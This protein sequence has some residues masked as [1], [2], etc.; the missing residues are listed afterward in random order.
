MNRATPLILAIALFMQ[1]MDSTVIATALPAI[2]IDIGTDPIAL[3]LA[4][5]SYL[6]ALAMFIP[7]SGWMGERFGVKRVFAASILVFVAGSILCAFADSLGTFVVYRF[8]QGMGGAMMMP[9]ARVILAR[10]TPRNELIRAMSWLTIPALIGPLAGP[11]VG[12]F[13]TTYFSWHWI[14]FINVPIGLVGV[15]AVAIF[16][17]GLPSTLVR[18]MDWPGFFLASISF[19]GLLFGLSVVSQPILPAGYGITATLLGL[20]AGLGYIWHA[21][22]AEHPLLQLSLFQYPLF[23][24]GIAGGFI[25]RIAMGATPFLLPLMLQLGFGLSPFQSGLI[26]FYSAVG[27]IAAKFTAPLVY[28]RLGF[29]PVALIA[30]FASFLVMTGIGF[31]QPATP[32]WIMAA[33][34]LTMGT[35]RST[36]MSGLN[37]MSFA[38]V[39]E[40]ENGQ[41]AALSSVGTQ[42]SFAL[43]IAIGGACLEF[44]SSQHAGPPSVADFHFSIYVVAAI[45]LFAFIP[46]RRITRATGADVTGQAH[47]RELQSRRKQARAQA[48]D[49]N[50]R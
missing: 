10:T 27:A 9:L 20:L 15:A 29:K 4:M 25:F 44:F 24:T 11:P 12:G 43:G 42:L 7:V 14:F 46:F 48:L 1:M 34:L 47:R 40:S 32:V 18:P 13:L 28:A 16:L 3:K 49:L 26:T 36:F 33:T 6:V 50:D 31:F 22:R 39:D 38:E 37:V 17:P 5:T 2:A 8:V 23:R 30:T 35:I 19:S 45:S 41:A 21:L